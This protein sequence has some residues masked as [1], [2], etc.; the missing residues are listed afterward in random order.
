MQIVFQMEGGLARFPGLARPITLSDA[1][2]AAGEPEELGQLIEAARFFDEPE[3]DPS[4]SVVPDGQRYVLSISD[5]ARS[6][7]V[8]RHD[9][10]EPPALAE[11]LSYV[12][13]KAMSVLRARAKPSAP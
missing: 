4:G 6:H 3:A 10:V 1:D 11:L 5:D 8:R 12:R 2:L 13:Q 9:P 7:T